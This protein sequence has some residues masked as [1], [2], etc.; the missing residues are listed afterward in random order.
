[1]KKSESFPARVAADVSKFRILRGWTITTSKKFDGSSCGLISFGEP[2]LGDDLRRA[3]IYPWRQDDEPEPANYVMC[4]VL[5][6]AL[7][8]L[9]LH[10][11]VNREASDDIEAGFVEDLCELILSSR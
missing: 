2:V 4:S 3:N 10:K 8:A 7:R 5:E 11:I 1:M 6:I 9:E